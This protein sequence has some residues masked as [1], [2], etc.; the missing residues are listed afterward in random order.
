MAREAY[1]DGY[2]HDIEGSVEDAEYGHIGPDVFMQAVEADA[3][4]TRKYHR[5]EDLEDSDIFDDWERFERDQANKAE[6]E[7]RI[8]FLEDPE[9]EDLLER[10]TKNPTDAD[11]LSDLYVVGGEHGLTEDAIAKAIKFVTE[12]GIPNG[13]LRMTL[14]DLQGKIGPLPNLTTKQEKEL[15]T[16]LS[17]T[18]TRKDSH[19]SR[20]NAQPVKTA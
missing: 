3:S 12:P 17:V 15:S 14:D 13:L 11:A 19:G 16:P 18:E 20:P 2:L 8:Q 7:Q 1:R 10:L 5:A 4:G 6:S 9:V